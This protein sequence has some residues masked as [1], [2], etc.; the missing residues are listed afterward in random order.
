VPHEELKQMQGA[1]WGSGAFDEV[2]DTIADVHQTVAGRLSPA[3]GERFLDIACGTGRV[4]ELAAASGATVVGVDLAPGLIEVAR[5]R[6]EERGL[7]IEYHVGDAEQLDLPD[8]SFDVVSSTFGLMFAPTQEA[9]AAELARVTRP[10]GR[11]GLA[12]WTPE[13]R[14]GEMFRL[15]G[16]FATA[17]P[18]SIPV[19]WGTE[20]RC[21]E[22]L[23]DAFELTFERQHNHW[24]YPSGEWSWEFMST[25]FGPTV[26]LLERLPPEQ[27]EELHQKMVAFSEQA[28]QGDRIVDEREYLLV[29]GTRR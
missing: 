7:D 16:S 25:R 10:G 5:R 6:A 2:A 21:R 11:I 20:D 13:G 4:C 29:L 19:L 22:L 3:A 28:R 23:G 9:A 17:P 8:A 15:Q 27:A 12:N 24:E 1:M 18:P 14:V 26:T